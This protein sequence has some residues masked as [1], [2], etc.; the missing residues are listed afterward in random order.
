MPEAVETPRVLAVMAHPDDAE[1]W[2]GGTLAAW[3]N[4]GVEVSYLVLTDGE[5]G[6]FDERTDRS[7]VPGIRRQEQERAAE[8]LGVKEVQFLGLGENSLLDHRRGVHVEVVRAIRR[9]RPHRVITWSP[10]WNWARFRSCHPDHLATGGLVLHAVY[11]DAGNLFALSELRAREDL[12][13]WT[14]G[15]IWLLNS[16][17]TNHWLDITATFDRKVAAVGAHA[18]QTAHYEDLQRH[19]RNRAESVAATAGWTDGRLAE[20]FQVVINR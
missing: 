13:P 18:S 12:E 14:V 11:P 8:L 5:A 17:H 9:L 1:F 3:T 19:L 4:D 6:G 2:A 10:E 7:L 16:P 20:G 15:E